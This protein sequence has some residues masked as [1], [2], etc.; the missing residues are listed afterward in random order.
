VATP[1]RHGGKERAEMSFLT[2]MTNAMGRLSEQAHPAFPVTIYYAF[3]QSETLSE[4]GTGSTGWETFLDAVHRA[5]FAL[6]GTWPIRTERDA[7]TR[8]IS[9]NALASSIILVG[10]PDGAGASVTSRRAFLPPE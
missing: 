1:Y 6:T 5:G 7:R 9:S 10:R 2:G 3:K 4:T 8:G